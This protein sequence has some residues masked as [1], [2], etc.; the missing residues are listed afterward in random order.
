MGT[1]VYFIVLIL[2]V[3]VVPD[4]FE[5]FNS[6]YNLAL[7]LIYFCLLIFHFYQNMKV[8]K[9]WL[10]FDVVF[11]I[12]FT[13]VHIQIPYFASIGIE[14]SHP[15]FVWINKNLVNF[16]T[17][18][19]V[20]AITCWLLGYSYFVNKGRNLQKYIKPSTSLHINY[21][22]YDII[23]LS[24][25]LV[26][27]GLAG[28]SLLSGVYD[29]GNSYNSGANYVY[30]I[31][32]S[33]LFLRII[34]FFK[35]FTQGSSIKYIIHRAFSY[36]IFSLVLILFVLLFL[37]AG[38]RGPVMQ[39]ALII[40]GLYGLIVK[41]ISLKTLIVFTVAGAFVFTLI[42]LGRGGDA[43]QFEEGNIFE[44]GYSS[45][46]T[47][48]EGN[49][50]EELATSVR[51]QYIALDVVPDKHPYLY[52][53]TFFTVG[54]GVIPF[55]GS[56]VLNIFSIPDMY[57]SSSSFFTIL[58]KGPNS[59]S[60][61]GSEILADIYINFGLVLTFV[62]MLIFGIFSAHVFNKATSRN[63]VYLLIFIILIY[64][65]LSMNRGM[66]FTPLKDIV[67]ILFFN[68]LFTRII[69]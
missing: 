48:E 51:L 13:I 11:L 8:S 30:L 61:T 37:F 50:T 26:F 34:Y 42:S 40:G 14:P 54:V 68:Y 60:G 18:M 47:Q 49:T 25:F 12:G 58:T 52:G 24:S 63:F 55:M 27:L 45:Y 28:T 56:A 16:A 15:Q 59:G 46:Q 1:I 39:V 23:L 22:K 32:V 35:D 33:L 36:K 5:V 2:L 64:S 7:S 9:N 62:I 41:P 6:N 57:K 38:D 69:K 4:R 31:L 43:S 21:F 10:R 66:L 53:V 65:A 19:S 20:V 67:Y 29:G 44:R 3:L 17:W